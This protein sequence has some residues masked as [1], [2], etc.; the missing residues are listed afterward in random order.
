MTKRDV[1]KDLQDAIRKMPPKTAELVREAVKKN[2]PELLRG[3]EKG[4]SK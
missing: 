2:A 1:K 3:S 4:K